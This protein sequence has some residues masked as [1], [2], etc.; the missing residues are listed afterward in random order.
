MHSQI[1]KSS[2]GDV[3]NALLERLTI[4]T[5]AK[6]RPRTWGCW[7]DAARCVFREETRVL[8]NYFVNLYNPDLMQVS[9]GRMC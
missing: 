1:R 8:S 6:V 2:A 3:G 9:V 5:D 7:I 4:R